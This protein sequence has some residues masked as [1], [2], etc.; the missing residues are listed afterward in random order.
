LRDGIFGRS[1]KVQ[2]F[3]RWWRTPKQQGQAVYFFQTSL[4]LEELADRFKMGDVSI[5]V[6]FSNGVSTEDFTPANRPSRERVRRSST[7]L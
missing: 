3:L 5:R 7:G 6:G 4:H 1:L 2:A